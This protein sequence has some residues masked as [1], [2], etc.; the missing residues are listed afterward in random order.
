MAD[1]EEKV[2]AAIDITDATFEEEII[3]F[4][5]V[6]VLDFWAT[7]CGPCRVQ[8]PIIEQL[9]EELKGNEMVKVAKIDVD[10]NELTS[11]AFQIRSIP[12]LVFFVNGEPVGVKPGVTQ[13]PALKE[14]IEKFSAQ[15]P[16]QP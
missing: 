4:P 11:N 2:H 8:G 6:V 9:A 1:T 12:S 3:K 5:G 13:L 15:I 7:W 14:F 16:A 10:A